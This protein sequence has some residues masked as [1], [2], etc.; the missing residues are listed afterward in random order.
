MSTH[1]VTLVFEDG[2][3]RRIRARSDQSLYLAALRH[4][5]RLLTDCREAACGTCKALCV[6]GEV[7]LEDYGSEALS[8][9][10]ARQGYTLPCQGQARSD[11]V[12]E[13]PYAAALAEL[14]KA[15]PLIA[16]VA[17]V[18]RVARAV[19]RLDLDPGDGPAPSFLP[20]QYAHL[21]VP[22]TAQQRSYSF[23]TA[24]GAAGLLR[25]YIKLIDGGAMSSYVA[26]RARPGDE[27]ALDGPFGH[28]YLRRPLRPIVMV[29]GGTGLAPMLSML[30]QLA[31]LSAVTPV[32]LLYGAAA[33]VDLFAL[34]QLQGYGAKGLALDLEG[35]VVTPSADWTGAV[36]QVTELLRPERVA[37]ADVYLCG[38]PAMIEAGRRLLAAFG[39][40]ARHIHAE[41]FL[42]S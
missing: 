1:A 24:P 18:E 40:P 7:A 3:A 8:A 21:A 5:I 15:P 12:L 29:A 13:L 4:G 26:G 37:G 9:E 34:E 27:V 32:R 30:D 28:F 41:T 6:D 36:G 16:R 10:E 17:A 19:M 22:G 14:P 25:F 23:A 11:C 38:P 35:S 42:P 33:S 2:A 31:A 39:V 20:G